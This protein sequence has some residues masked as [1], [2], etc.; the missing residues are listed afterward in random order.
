MPNV[1]VHLYL[2]CFVVLFDKHLLNSQNVMTSV[3]IIRF[4]CYLAPVNWHFFQ[5][6]YQ[7]LCKCASDFR[8]YYD[9]KNFEKTAIGNVRSSPL[10]FRWKIIHNVTGLTS[11]LEFVFHK[12]NLNAISKRIFCDRRKVT[13]GNNNS[14]EFLIKQWPNLSLKQ[15]DAPKGTRGSGRR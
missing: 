2:N 10:I 1:D 13:A 11:Y 9:T 8:R 4:E 7:I 14:T 15:I 5:C 12:H 6:K 3:I